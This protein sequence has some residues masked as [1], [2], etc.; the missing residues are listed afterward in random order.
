MKEII[1]KVRDGDKLSDRELDTAIKW[2]KST[3][4]LLE[5][6]GERYHLVWKDVYME[7]KR[8]EGFKEARRNK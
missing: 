2:Y 5:P 6:F 1:Q 7:Q 3:A 8:L 4:G